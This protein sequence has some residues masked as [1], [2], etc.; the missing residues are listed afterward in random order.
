MTLTLADVFAPVAPC[1]KCDGTLLLEAEDIE[2][3]EETLVARCWKCGHTMH[4]DM[5]F[6]ERF[7]RARF[8][9]IQTWRSHSSPDG[10]PNGFIVTGQSLFTTSEEIAALK[11]EVAE[12]G[13]DGEAGQKLT[14]IID[15]E[16]AVA[17]YLARGDFEN[18]YHKASAPHKCAI[19]DGHSPMVCR[20][21]VNWVITSPGGLVGEFFNMYG[22]ILLAWQKL[23]ALLTDNDED[24]TNEDE[25]RIAFIECLKEVNRFGYKFKAWGQRSIV[26]SVDGEDIQ[27]WP[28]VQLQNLVVF[29]LKSFFKTQKYALAQA[30]NLVQADLDKL[31]N[32]EG[33]FSVGF[34]LCISNKFTANQLKPDE[35]PEYNYPVRVFVLSTV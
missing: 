28:D 5:P 12:E 9:G 29:E 20:E 17:V 15:R 21:N 33:R 23:A 13:P 14:Q 24:I 19:G 22:F 1:T 7:V 10:F 35:L 32:Y 26:I 25:A 6:L 2:H 31:K 3:M 11:E 30:K 8:D 27:H 4:C 16:E 34:L 18:A